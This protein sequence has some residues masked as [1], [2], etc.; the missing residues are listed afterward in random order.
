MIYPKRLKPG[1]TI[2]LVAPCSGVPSE[3]AEKCIKLL[4]DM[5]FRVKAADNLAASKGGYMAG[6]EEARGRWLNEMFAD[7]EV[8][9]VFCLRGG[10]GGNRIVEFLDLDV[11]R[12]NRKIFAGYSNITTMHLIFN[13]ECDLIT[14]HAPM[15]SS[16]MLEHFDEESKAAFFEALSGEGEYEYKAPAGMPLKVARAGR[17]SGILTGGNLCVMCASL[18][19][20]Y[21]METKG[22]ILFI[23]EIGGHI[24]NMDRNLYQLK[25]AGK[26]D[27]ISGILLGQFTDCELEDEN[28]GIVEAVL[29]VVNGLD[30][31]IMYNV[32]SGHGF[33]MI[34]L[35]MGAMCEMDTERRTIKWTEK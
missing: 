5:G 8:D 20:P 17:A 14:Y 29:D 18:G 16:N 26:L 2:G 21:E 1:D 15:V 4:E 33:P 32:Q 3:R 10:D 35:P 9:A 7:K 12:N 22:R 30:I 13:Q 24:G 28:Y 11:V 31:P 23:E 34:T 6:G 25:N 19:T 27:E